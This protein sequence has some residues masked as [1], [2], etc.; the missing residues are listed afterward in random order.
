MRLCGI[1]LI[2]AGG[3]GAQEI[4]TVQVASGVA[5]ITDL[6]NAG[7][8]SGRLFLVQEGAVRTV[9]NGSMA[10]AAFLDIRSK[11][12]GTGE[13]GLIGLAFPPGFAQKQRFYVVRANGVDSPP[14]LV[15]VQ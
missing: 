2:R 7:D 15:W 1:T 5:N 11:T 9:R 4:W 8:N 3:L 14:V 6:Q 13:R 10:A 12:T